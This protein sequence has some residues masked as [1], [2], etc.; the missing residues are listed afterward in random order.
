M[1]EAIAVLQ[2]QAKNNVYAAIARV[3]AKL[4]PILADDEAEVPTKTGGKYSYRYASLAQVWRSIRPLLADAGLAVVYTLERDRERQE[5]TVVLRVVHAASAT[6]HQVEVPLLSYAGTMQGLGGVITYARRYA[7]HLAFG[8]AIEGED[9]D[10]SADGS[11]PKPQAKRARAPQATE[12]SPD[13]YAQSA[14]SEEGAGRLTKGQIALID[15]ALVRRAREMPGV[16]ATDI[17][18]AL[19]TRFEWVSIEDCPPAFMNELMAEIRTWEPPVSAGQ[20][21]ML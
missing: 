8:L 13:P 11:K 21:E 2:E 18:N 6:H 17:S 14:R 1:S 9:R 19:K 16:T 10:L 3:Q 5:M 20:G 4:D 12:H 7:L 15:G